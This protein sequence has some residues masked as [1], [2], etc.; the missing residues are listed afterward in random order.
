M[1]RPWVVAGEDGIKGCN[2]IEVGG[3]EA[4]EIGR[5][6]GCFV[7]ANVNTGVD[8]SGIGSQG[9][10]HHVLNS[11]AN[12]VVDKLELKMDWYSSL[13]FSDVG[14]NGFTVDAVTR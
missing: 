10:D 13:I 1:A 5:I 8:T 2:S 4:T 14:P 7:A 3:L 12:G 6:E 11:F 9:V